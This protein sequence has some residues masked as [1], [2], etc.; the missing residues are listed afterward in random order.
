MDTNY[1]KKY[2]KYKNKY[3][4]LKQQLGGTNATDLINAFQAGYNDA[5]IG[6][7]RDLRINNRFRSLSLS[8]YYKDGYAAGNAVR[9]DNGI[10]LIPPISTQ[11]HR[12]NYDFDDD[13]RVPTD[14][15]LFGALQRPRN[16]ISQQHNMYIETI[17]GQRKFTRNWAHNRM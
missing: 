7:P 10:P 9:V 2:E 6:L 14:D 8:I 11:I 17:N 16:A 5:L 13:A 1:K 4:S 12:A 3:M 15:E